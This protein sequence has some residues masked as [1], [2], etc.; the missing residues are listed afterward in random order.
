[1]D[2]NS[3]IRLSKAYSVKILHFD[4][5]GYGPQGKLT[6]Q[7]WRKACLDNLLAGKEVF[8]A[9]QKAVFIE[10]ADSRGIANF[11]YLQNI[12]NSKIELQV[13]GNHSTC[14]LDFVTCDFDSFLTL[15]NMEF[16]LNTCFFGANFKNGVWFSN[17]KFHSMVNFSNVVFY[18]SADFEKVEFEDSALFDGAEFCQSARFQEAQFKEFSIFVNSKFFNIAN[19]ESAKFFRDALFKCTNFYIIADF[20]KT[21]FYKRVNF[22][23]AIFIGDANFSQTEFKSLCEFSVDGYSAIFEGK[24]NFESAIFD[25][26]GHFEG[27]IFK[28]KIPE[29]RGCKIDT[30]RLEFS[31]KSRFPEN[32]IEEGTIENISFLKRLSDEHGQ[33][34]Q[35][36][37][38]NALELNAKSAQVKVE[39]E[40]VFPLFRVKEED[41]WFTKTTYL[42]EVLSN[43]GRS[44]TR[45]IIGYMILIAASAIFAMSYSTYSESPSAEQQVL[46]KPIDD[47]PPPLKL[48]Y[49]RAVVEYAMFRAGGLMDFTDTGKQNNAVNCRLFEEP[50]E[51]PLMR[52]WGIFKGI[53][54]IALLFLAALGLRNKYRI[55]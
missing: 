7:V 10:N 41:W 39:M 26:I 35:A 47:Q 52:A 3:N 31:N 9:W 40:K 27:V 45:P 46:C 36:L 8:E 50:I 51:P 42:Y 43:Y 21:I 20:I 23:G 53:A 55:K 18:N 14:T 13:V 54:S 6:R 34:D 32:D 5:D 33:T 2:T 28:T 16:Y 48:P 19:F 22:G 37:R 17:S 1:M 30:T 12:G 24:S 29:F 49:G 44:F 38:F 11:D 25:T 15:S 4:E